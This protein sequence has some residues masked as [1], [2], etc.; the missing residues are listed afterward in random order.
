MNDSVCGNVSNPSG[1][2]PSTHLLIDDNTT[3]NVL[4]EDEYSIES[5][6]I[7]KQKYLLH[8]PIP[9]SLI[10]FVIGLILAMTTENNNSNQFEH[11]NLM[12]KSSGYVQNIIANVS[13]VSK[14]T[15]NGAGYTVH[16][17]IFHLT[18]L[19]PKLL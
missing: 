8:Y 17:P 19:N 10:A 2:G 4:D 16:T 3:Q 13:G 9:A 15:S 12:N 18:I 7:I 6:T 14:D 1:I 11:N 5:Q